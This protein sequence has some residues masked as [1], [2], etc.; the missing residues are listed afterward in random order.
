[1]IHY[2]LFTIHYS[3]NRHFLHRRAEGSPPYG[4]YRRHCQRRADVG[5]RP[6]GWYKIAVRSFELRTAVFLIQS[7]ERG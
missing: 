3:L 5:I 7:T 1:M 6:Y 4:V 2:S